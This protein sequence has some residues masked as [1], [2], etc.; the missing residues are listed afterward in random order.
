LTPY[1]DTPPFSPFESGIALHP[2]VSSDFFRCPLE[3]QIQAN[4]M[5]EKLRIARS[6]MNRKPQGQIVKYFS[7]S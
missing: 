2:D 7:L 4:A 6:A 5:R 3:S 1:A